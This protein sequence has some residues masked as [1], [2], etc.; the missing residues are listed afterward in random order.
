M[1][2]TPGLLEELKRRRVFRV[3]GMYAVVGWLLLQIGEVT[4]EPLGL[5]EGALKTLIFVVALGFPVAVALGWIFDWT[6]E[7]LVRTSEDA[8][9]R[10]RFLGFLLRTDVALLVCLVAAVAVIGL[11]YGGYRGYEFW[12]QVRWARDVAQPELV[13]RI[14]QNDFA[15]AFALAVQL[16]EKLGEQPMLESVWTLISAPVAFETEP[17]GALVSYRRYDDPDA[18]WKPLGETPIATT[19]V[20]RGPSLWRIEK[21]GYATRTFARLPASVDFEQFAWPAQYVLDPPEASLEDTV[22]VEGREYF[23]VSLAGFPVAGSYVLDRFFID[24]TEVRNDRY[25]EFVDAGGYRRPEF[26]TVP[27]RD[28]DRILSFEEAMARFLDSTGRPG[29]ATWVGGHYPEGLADH[30]V[31]GVSWYEAVAY[32]KFRGRHLP[33]VYH[34]AAA[35]LPDIEI[36]EPLAPALA[37][38]SNLESVGTLP[39]GSTP[40]L[41]AAGAS[42]MFGNVAEWVWTARGEDQRFILGLGWSDPAYNAS[43]A[44]AASPWSRLPI[45]GLRLATYPNGEPDPSLLARVEVPTVDYA[46]LE[47][48]TDDALALIEKKMNDSSRMPIRATEKPVELPNGTLAIRAEIEEPYSNETLPVYLLA[49]E[50]VEPP[51]EAVVWFGGINA[52]ISRDNASLFE[53]GGRFSSFLRQSGRLLV[54]PIWAGTFERNDGSSFRRFSGSAGG[55]SELIF[56]W[57]RDLHLTLDYLETREDVDPERIGFVG[58]SL[59]AA[60]GAHIIAGKERLKTAILWSG[61]FS[62]SA[63]PENSVLSAS[64]ARRTRLPVLMLNGRHDFVFPLELQQ[65]YF[66]LLGT[67]IADKRHVVYDAGH[68]GWP[69]GEFV[70]DN[71]DWLDRYLGPVAKPAS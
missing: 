21:P 11:A 36:L 52:I 32:A 4:F 59:G 58:L 22:P 7:G 40:G 15:G 38:Q 17:S 10:V 6:S 35:A 62:A 56:S 68:F 24:R 18:E 30:P 1:E 29:P 67:P 44:S 41:S 19:R 64:L 42:D 37:A 25:Q 46:S 27:F 51:Y 13:K 61:G 20:P 31:G 55:Q 26:W 8:R 49:P 71:L 66:E 47:P 14:E 28:G 5:P 48:L 69:L 33:T 3:S 50:N 43:L 23:Q 63:F 60:V 65:A 12:S 53:A 39:V 70:R 16:E 54:M 34:W 2:R 57:G 45:Q 9:S